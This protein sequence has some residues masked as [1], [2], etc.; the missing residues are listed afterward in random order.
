MEALKENLLYYFEKR[1]FDFEKSEISFAEF[2]PQVLVMMAINGLFYNN[3]ESKLRLDISIYT[4]LY[5][6]VD[7]LNPRI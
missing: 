6:V 2:H 1:Y 7:T 4:S 3:R 5:I